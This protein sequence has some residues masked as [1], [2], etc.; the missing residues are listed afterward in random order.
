LTDGRGSQQAQSLPGQQL[1]YAIDDLGG[2]ASLG[3]NLDAK[4][5][6]SGSSETAYHVIQPPRTRWLVAAREDALAQGPLCGGEPET[7]YVGVGVVEA[8]DEL[9]E[10][11]V[12]P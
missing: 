5:R 3:G 9:G 6:T 8:C 10:V 4:H 1:E 2:R 12:A 11:I 7:A